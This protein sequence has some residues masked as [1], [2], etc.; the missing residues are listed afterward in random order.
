MSN[1][2]QFPSIALALSL[3]CALGGCVDAVDD[4]APDTAVAEQAIYHHEVRLR[5]LQAV[6]L[7]EGGDEIYLTASQSSGGGVNV[8]RPP[9]DPDYW[10]FDHTGELS[11][12]NHVGTII[13]DSLLIVNLR[14]Q[15][16]GSQNQ[17]GTIDF[18]LDNAGKPKTFDTPT[19]KFVTMDSGQFVVRFTNGANYK[20]WFQVGP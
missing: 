16:N 2:L 4:D 15:D 9:G 8:I 6:V 3:S 10:R 1:Q 5:R 13:A 12:D 20:A 11:M 19:G 17:I 7:E 14:E 18:L